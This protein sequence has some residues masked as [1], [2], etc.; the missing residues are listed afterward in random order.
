M[1]ARP[2]LIL[3]HERIARQDIQRGR[4][5]ELARSAAGTSEPRARRSVRSE[6]PNLGGLAI[7]HR[8]G[9]IGQPHHAGYGA[10]HIGPVALRGT[11]QGNRAAQRNGIP[12]EHGGRIL[13]DPDAGA[14][15]HRRGER[16]VANRVVATRDGDQQER[17]TAQNQRLRHGDEHSHV[18][19]LCQI[20]RGPRGHHWDTRPTECVGSLAGHCTPPPT[21]ASPDPDPAQPAAAPRS[22]PGIVRGS[23]G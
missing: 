17:G 8:D 16:A 9:T 6:Y 1:D 19:V 13:D 2:E 4:A 15:A 22:A 5:L 12:I 10:E 7:Q 23:S 18:K 14:V 21:K 20:S 11:D 3:H